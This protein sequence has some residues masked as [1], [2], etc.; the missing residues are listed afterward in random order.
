MGFS[1]CVFS[2]LLLLNDNKCHF[3]ERNIFFLCKVI[4]PSLFLLSSA[5]C[6]TKFKGDAF[7]VINS[8]LQVKCR[9]E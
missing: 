6:F 9:I 2:S 7:C 1:V 5:L 4:N 3:F 8:C